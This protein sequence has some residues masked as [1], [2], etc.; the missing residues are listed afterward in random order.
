MMPHVH[1]LRSDSGK[2]VPD[3]VILGV[4]GNEQFQTVKRE[5]VLPGEEHGAH[6][7]DFQFLHVRLVGREPA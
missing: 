1:C 5:L 6:A 2:H 3:N 4:A 7:H